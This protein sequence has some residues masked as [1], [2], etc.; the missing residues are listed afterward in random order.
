LA[1]QLNLSDNGNPSN[2][3]IRN[4][5]REHFKIKSYILPPT[6]QPN[7]STIPKTHP[8]PGLCVSFQIFTRINLSQFTLNTKLKELHFD[9]RGNNSNFF[10]NCRS[11]LVPILAASR[12]FV[13]ADARSLNS[14]FPMLVVINL[15]G[16]CKDTQ[17]TIKIKILPKL[18]GVG[19][20]SSIK[21]NAAAVLDPRCRCQNLCSSPLYCSSFFFAVSRLVASLPWTLGPFR[22]LLEQLIASS[23]KG[24]IPKLSLEFGVWGEKSFV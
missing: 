17:R 1:C 3:K 8:F 9:G 21:K 6:I 7:D 24:C 16:I 2:H 13:A 4:G 20:Q 5:R 22:S 11:L 10:L 19:L 14:I 12:L 18:F 15:C 23:L